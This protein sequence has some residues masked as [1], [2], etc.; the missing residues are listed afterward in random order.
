MKY[1]LLVSDL[2]GTLLT[3]DMK[4]SPENAEAIKKIT[5]LGIEFSVSSG[6]TLHEIPLTVRENPYIRVTRY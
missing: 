5:E 2:D 6:R 1:K 3:E 4:I